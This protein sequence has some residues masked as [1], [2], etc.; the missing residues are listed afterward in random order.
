MDDDITPISVGKRVIFSV[1]VV[2]IPIEYGHCPNS[3]AQILTARFPLYHSFQPNRY[4]EAIDIT[5]TEN[6]IY[7][8]GSDSEMDT[9][10]YLYED[11]LDLFY[12]LPYQINKNDNDGCNK[13][14]KLTQYLKKN[15][16]YILLVTTHSLNETGSFFIY[17]LGPNNATLKPSGEYDRYMYQI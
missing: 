5:V 8:L 1:S 7:T 16:T 14:F 11:K 15:R 6:G 10:G 17:V 9:D 3:T 12:P 4:S 2:E 13:Q